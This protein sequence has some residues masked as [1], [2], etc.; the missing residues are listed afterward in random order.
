[1]GRV[2]SKE[3]KKVLD[4]RS[5]ERNSQR[6]RAANVIRLASKERTTESYR[7]DFIGGRGARWVDATCL[8]GANEAPRRVEQKSRRQAGKRIEP[9]LHGQPVF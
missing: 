8:T 9:T 1:M 4:S 6:V 2:K 7:E 5:I 3:G